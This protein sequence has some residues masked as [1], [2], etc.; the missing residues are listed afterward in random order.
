MRP[1]RSLNWQ[2]T[3][4]SAAALLADGTQPVIRKNR[5]NLY[6]HTHLVRSRRYDVRW[7]SNEFNC[8]SE[9]I[10]PG[11]KTVNHCENPLRAVWPLYV[12]SHLPYNLLRG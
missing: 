5:Q 12:R 9:R 1:L 4:S 8:E 2:E 3:G 7:K 6:W 11:Q 10:A